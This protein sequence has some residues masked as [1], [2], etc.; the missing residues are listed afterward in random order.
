M[1]TLTAL[2][3]GHFLLARY[4]APGTN[5]SPSGRRVGS[6]SSL[7]DPLGRGLGEGSPES[8]SDRKLLAKLRIAGGLTVALSARIGD[9]ASKRV[10]VRGIY[11]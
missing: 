3:E 1:S 8:F 2:T 7:L 5:G 6:S 9:S 10:S 11:H 4:V